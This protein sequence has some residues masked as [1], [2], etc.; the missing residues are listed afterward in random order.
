MLRCTHAARTC[1]LDGVTRRTAASCASCPFNT[2]NIHRE[3]HT[4]AE[5]EDCCRFLRPYTTTHNTFASS[6]HRRN[7]H[8]AVKSSTS[9]VYIDAYRGSASPREDRVTAVNHAATSIRARSGQHQ[10]QQPAGALSLSSPEKSCKSSSSSSQ[11]SHRSS[12]IPLAVAALRENSLFGGGSNAS[13]SSRSSKKGTNS[14]VAGVKNM[15]SSC[16]QLPNGCPLAQ[17]NRSSG[18][19][20]AG[21]DSFLVSSTV[22]DHEAVDKS[23]DD[24][25]WRRLTI[26][27]MFQQTTIQCPFS[28]SSRSVSFISELQEEFMKSTRSSNYVVNR[29]NSNSSASYFVKENLLSETSPCYREK[30]TARILATAASEGAGSATSS[31]STPAAEPATAGEAS[32][33]KESF[34]GNSGEKGGGGGGGNTTNTVPSRTKEA[35]QEV[36][37]H[38]EVALPL[39]LGRNRRPADHDVGHDETATSSEEARVQVPSSSS[40]STTT[41]PEVDHVDSTRTDGIDVSSATPPLE[42]AG[43]V[44]TG[45]VG[46]VPAQI[47]GGGQHTTTASGGRAR[48]P[49]THLLHPAQPPPPPTPVVLPTGPTTPTSLPTPAPAARVEIQQEEEPSA[50]EITTTTVP[51]PSSTAPSARTSDVES[52]YKR[53]LPDSLILFHSREGQRKLAECLLHENSGGQYAALSEQFLTQ[54]R[55]PLCG[56]S[57]IVM[58]LNSLAVDPQRVW[59]A[60]WRWHTEEMLMSCLRGLRPELPALREK[61]KDS[62]GSSSTTSSDTIFKSSACGGR[63]SPSTTS[64]TSWS[65]S[66]SSRPSSFSRAKS[67]NSSCTVG[68]YNSSASLCGSSGVGGET[69]SPDNSPCSAACDAFRKRVASQGVTME[70][71]A[72]L[73]ECNGL[74]TK[75]QYAD[76]ETTMLEDFREVL[77]ELFYHD[78]ENNNYTNA[79]RTSSSASASQHSASAS[80]SSRSSS[81]TTR[82]EHQKQFHDH[83]D[84][85]AQP[86]S[87]VDHDP[88][89]HIAPP[90]PTAPV[91]NNTMLNN[92]QE[93]KRLVVSFSRQQLGQT[94]DGHYSPVAAFHPESDMVL[95]LDVARFKYPPYWVSVEQLWN[96][97]K[98]VDPVTKHSRG[99]FVMSKENCADDVES[100]SST[101]GST[102]T[103]CSSSD[104]ATSPALH[105]E[106]LLQQL[107]KR[108]SSH[109]RKVL[110]RNQSSSG[111][112]V[113]GF[114]DAKITEVSSQD[115]QE[116]H[117]AVDPH[118]MNTLNPLAELKDLRKMNTTTTFT[119]CAPQ[120]DESRM[121]STA[122]VLKQHQTEQTALA[123]AV[124]QQTRT[125]NKKK[126]KKHHLFPMHTRWERELLTLFALSDARELVR[127]SSRLLQNVGSSCHNFDNEELLKAASPRLQEEVDILSQMFREQAEEGGM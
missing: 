18:G 112:R 102:G 84:H 88:H 36:R 80:S 124:V 19:T 25:W 3:M 22:D 77:Q 103:T 16:P 42:D 120:G 60:P 51:P 57:S 56:P 118:A 9:P 41:V 83:H 93:Q 76:D 8:Q 52:F 34:V 39:A 86:S 20:G 97:M 17:R 5:I 63:P 66:S 50:Q 4:T 87:Q 69:T 7:E 125:S 30:M 62:P 126:K 96:A 67:S 21:A 123:A 54:S 85:P 46:V 119:T 43:S 11:K 94:G 99:F 91:M 38:R 68:S 23:S 75:V 6:S 24:P 92:N 40:I 110:I 13:A 61:R 32:H 59:Q 27:G 64:S 127:S 65:T 122:A 35:K 55:P 15:T 113:S 115:Q 33:R 108:Y 48:R 105:R 2:S 72:F 74:T 10:H 89:H 116:H 121:R 101:A 70:E 73:S 14:E 107:I 114:D 29:S 81:S 26:P 45:S 49:E 106:Q 79:D 12:V 1:T 47:N 28:T 58:V 98:A 37:R 53:P 117:E 104:S 111:G 100:S 109:F 44:V 31:S 78:D 82:P 90:Q 71:F 95:V